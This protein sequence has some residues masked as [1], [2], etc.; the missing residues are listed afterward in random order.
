MQLEL[1]SVT[2]PVLALWGG[3]LFLLLV[4]FFIGFADS[5]VR[6]AKK[7]EAAETKAEIVRTQG[8]KKLAEAEALKATLP[9]LKDDPGLLRLKMVNGAPMLELDGTAANARSISPDQ[10]KRLIELITVMRPW[11]ESS[12]QPA[13]PPTTPVSAPVPRAVPTPIPATPPANA[14]KDITKLSIV[15]Q[16][17]TVLQARLVDTPLG[18]QGI[19][20]QE[21]LQ[22]GVEVYVGVQ[23]FA[24]VDEVP[25]ENIKTAI[26]AAIAEWEQKFT[27]GL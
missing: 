5:N 12:G 15:Q 23:K 16:I 3:G 10:R 9:P 26:R 7:I 11:V 19:R 27:P 14:E 4:G 6:S 1:S 8:E 18:S 17:D 25:D 21:S 13:T 20:L 2:V 22:G 24:S